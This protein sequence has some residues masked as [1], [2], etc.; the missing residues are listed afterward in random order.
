MLSRSF[1]DVTDFVL[2]FNG[3]KI[4]SWFDCNESGIDFLLTDLWPTD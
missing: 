2:R 4:Y 1:M 3:A